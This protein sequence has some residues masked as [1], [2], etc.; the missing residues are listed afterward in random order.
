MIVS[1][2]GTELA[3]NAIVQSADDHKVTWHCIAPGGAERFCRI[4]RLTPS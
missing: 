2:N 4:A 3:S 1:D